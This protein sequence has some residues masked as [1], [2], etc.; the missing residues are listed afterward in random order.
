[1]WAERGGSGEAAEE[2]A[3]ASAQ[4]GALNTMFNGLGLDLE[5]VWNPLKRILVREKHS[6]TC[7][8]NVTLATVTRMDWTAARRD[9]RLS[10]PSRS[11]TIRPEPGQRRYGGGGD[12]KVTSGMNSVGDPVVSFLEGDSSAPG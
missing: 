6:P 7:L 3:G 11:V 5:R 4:K 8:R 9:Q 12:S 10:Q 2:R 1:M